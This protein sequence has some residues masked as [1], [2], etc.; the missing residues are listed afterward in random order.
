M[1]TGP[2]AVQWQFGPVQVQ[3]L[4]HVPGLRGEPQVRAPLARWLGDAQ[5]A[6][7]LA[8]DAWGRPRLLAP[9]E[10]RDA[11]WSHSGERLLLAMGR[12]VV[13][14]VDLE[15]LRPRPR[16]LE[17]AERYFTAAEAAH[18][19]AIAPA[20]REAAFLRLWCAKEALLKAHGRGLAFGLHRLEFGIED[21]A[22]PV[23]LLACDPALGIAADWQLRE[24]TPEPG[25]HA[26]VAWYPR[27]A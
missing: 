19:R 26:A 10:D 20:Q 22:A 12:E 21:D 6:P 7:P 9:Y 11:G 18:L 2:A 1:S 27:R 8:R 16:A 13:L 14:G 5:A 17:L 4:P 15:R 25:Y 24:W 3:A 23:R